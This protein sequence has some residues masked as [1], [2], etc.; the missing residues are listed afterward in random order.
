[1]KTNTYAIFINFG[2]GIGN[3]IDAL[4]LASTTTKKIRRNFSQIATSKVPG[5]IT[6]SMFS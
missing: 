5:R 1:M 4:F 3:V 6:T 2:D